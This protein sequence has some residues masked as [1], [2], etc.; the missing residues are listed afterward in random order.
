MSHAIEGDL[1]FLHDHSHFT[2]VIIK[3]EN[4]IPVWDCSNKSLLVKL[5]K[6]NLESLLY[7]PPIGSFWFVR[8]VLPSVVLALTLLH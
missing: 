4:Y 6:D 1:H 3:N 2:V 7:W 8:V 5:K